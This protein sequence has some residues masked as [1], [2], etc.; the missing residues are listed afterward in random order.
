MA[1][2]SFA[3][4][5]LGAK[6]TSLKYDGTELLYLPDSPQPDPQP[7]DTFDTRFAWGADICAPGVAQE[8]GVADHGNFWTKVFTKIGEDYSSDDGNFRLSVNF[9]TNG[10]D[11]I[12]N[13]LVTNISKKILPFTFA[14]HILLPIKRRPV[15][16]WCKK[17]FYV[18][19]CVTY[20]HPSG[21]KL[22][23]E[24]KELNWLGHWLT[25]GGWNN[26]YNIGLE[27]TN[28]NDDVLSQAVKNNTGWQLAP[29]ETKTWQ[30]KLTVQP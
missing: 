27:L 8:D 30:I 14:D 5:P 26:Q 29:N 7:G 3:I 18:A 17:S 25:E 16:P 23:F 20:L 1:K 11:F 13:Y 22:T 4:R 19:N 10:D 6:I 2:M 28:A 12:R 21:L 24:S 9:Q 15:K